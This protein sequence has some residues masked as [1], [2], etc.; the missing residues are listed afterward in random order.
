MSGPDPET[1]ELNADEAKTRTLE[2]IE[3]AYLA[4][5]GVRVFWDELW[6]NGKRVDLE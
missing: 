2:G 5:D 4:P 3:A 6:I 1:P